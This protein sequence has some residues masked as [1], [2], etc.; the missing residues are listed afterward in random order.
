M[1]PMGSTAGFSVRFMPLGMQFSYGV[2]LRSNHKAVSWP[3]NVY[4]TIAYPRTH[5]AGVLI[6]VVH[7]TYPLDG[8]DC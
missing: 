2:H 3:W 8:Q 7:W 5:L 6:N 1:A 4:A